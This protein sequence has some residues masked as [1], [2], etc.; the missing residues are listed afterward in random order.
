MTTL[1]A[2]EAAARH[3]SFK[4]AAQELSVTPG[5]VSHQIKALEGELGT[6]LFQRQHRGVALTAEGQALF[7]TLSASFGRISKRLENIRQSDALEK[8]TVGSTTAVAALWLSPAIIRFWREFPNLSIDQLTQDTVFLPRVDLDFVIRYGRDSN[9]KLRQTPLYRDELVPVGTPEMARDLADASL[10]ELAGRWLIHLE[11]AGRD[12]T[13][14]GEWFKQLGH[15]G[16]LGAGTRVTNYSVALQ[17]AGKGAGL[18]LGWRR[19][20]QPLITA[21][22]LSV[23]GSH[24]LTAPREFYL[25]EYSDDEL[26]E[27]AATFK[28]WI[29]S[30]VPEHS[31]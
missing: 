18:V 27:K 12:W 15:A 28:K 11:S 5:A 14:W 17:L 9:S 2:F 3:L 4:N 26:S 22:Q 24:V 20:V 16:D 8:I 31:T 13:T 25:V 1:S 7:E 10:P 19:L 6:V 21:G 30:E 23:V 29:L